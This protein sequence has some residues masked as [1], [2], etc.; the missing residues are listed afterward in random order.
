M[1][2]LQA[3][4]VEIDEIDKLMAELFCKRMDAVK[5]VVEYKKTNGM[6]VLDAQREELVV[7]KNSERLKVAEYREYYEDFIRHTMAVSRAMQKKILSRDMVAYQGAEG[8]FTHIAAQALYPHGTLTPCATWADVFDAVTNGEVQCGVLPFENSHAGDVSEVLDLCYATQNIVVS[9]VI[10][11]PISQNLLCVKGAKLADIKKIISH[12]QALS[13]SAK[14]IKSL[15]V[16]VQ[17][18]P[19]TAIAAEHVAKQ[20]DKSLA[21]IASA[22]TAELYGLSMLMENVN[23]SKDNTT[24]FIVIEKNENTANYC[25]KIAINSKEENEHAK[26]DGSQRFSLLFTSKHEVGSLSK[27]IQAVASFGYNMECI[28]SRPIP[29]ANWEYYFYTE[30]VG[31]PTEELLS[32][33][34]ESCHTMRLLGVYKRQV[35][36]SR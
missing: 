9:E 16:E 4:R 23:E 11:L 17:S 13:Q 29:H 21:A 20:A 25:K 30:L 35:A 32:A 7:Q 31:I 2:M 6:A 18:C 33:I 28:K 22:K 15:G 5:N 19:N 24:R 12:P 14:M 3:A 27:I 26:K 34:K 1:D 36:K 10:D 8:A